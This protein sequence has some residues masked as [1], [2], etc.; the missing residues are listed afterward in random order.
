MATYV[1]S[2]LA[3][4]HYERYIEGMLAH[5]SVYAVVAACFLAAYSIYRCTRAVH[6]YRLL[7][8]D[9]FRV[10]LLNLLLEQP[11]CVVCMLP[12]LPS[13]NAADACVACKTCGVLAHHACLVGYFTTKRQHEPDCMQCKAR[14]DGVFFK[15]N[16]V[17]YSVQVAIHVP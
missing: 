9:N 7:H 8:Q 10:S 1:C 3:G 12:F 4:V 5:T 16:E 14:N 17:R 15:I 11:G 6:W 2:F 13:D